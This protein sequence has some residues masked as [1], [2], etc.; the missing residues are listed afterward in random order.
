MMNKD[1]KEPTEKVP[2]CRK[3]PR[4]TGA[5]FGETKLNNIVMV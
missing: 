4:P 2:L 5:S 3:P 1:T